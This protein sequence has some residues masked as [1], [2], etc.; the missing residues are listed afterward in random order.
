[1]EPLNRPIDDPFF[2]EVRRR[3][4]DVDI[5]LLPPHEPDDDW[6]ESVVDALARVVTRRTR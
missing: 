6:D 3:R 5:V 2:A 4:P 1:M